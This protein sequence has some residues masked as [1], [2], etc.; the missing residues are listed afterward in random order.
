MVSG[1]HDKSLRLW[2]RSKEALVL[3]EE[4]EMVTNIYDILLGIHQDFSFIKLFSMISIL[5]LDSILQHD[6]KIIK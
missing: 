6:P 2:E 3:E 4:R 1:S 5:V